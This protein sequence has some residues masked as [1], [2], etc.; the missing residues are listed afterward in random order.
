MIRTSGEADGYISG[1]TC[2]FNSSGP[3]LARTL[4]DDTGNRRFAH[5]ILPLLDLR[6]EAPRIPER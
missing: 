4:A 5:F 1:L 3:W 2:P 6:A